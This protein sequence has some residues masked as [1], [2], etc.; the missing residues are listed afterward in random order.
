[1][2][3][4]TKHQNRR[5][6]VTCY[7]N[8][9]YNKMPKS[10]IFGY[11]LYKLLYYQIMLCLILVGKQFLFTFFQ[12]QILVRCNNDIWAP[13]SEFHIPPRTSC[14]KE[15]LKFLKNRKFW[16]IWKIENFE[17]KNRKFSALLFET[18]VKIVFRKHV[19]IVLGKILEIFFSK[20]SFGKIKFFFCNLDF[21]KFFWNLHKGDPCFF[22]FFFFDY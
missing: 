1:M 14:R 9:I 12:K 2:L 18:S 22:R 4:I 15:I 11:M 5:F 17:K 16:K 8:V 6:L 20:I 10:A 3:Y 13:S 21:P 7:T 19:K